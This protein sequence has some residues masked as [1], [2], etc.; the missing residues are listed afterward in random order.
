MDNNVSWY[1]KKKIERTIK[2]LNNRNMEGYYV[3]DKIELIEQLKEFIPESSLVGVGDSMTLFETG[4]IDLKFLNVLMK[5][6][7]IKK[8]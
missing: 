8:I 5:L 6:W 4:V 2:N 3:N 7:I 1:I